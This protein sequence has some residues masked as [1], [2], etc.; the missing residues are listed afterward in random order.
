MY[1]QIARKIS[2]YE[3]HFAD[4]KYSKI[5]EKASKAALA[6]NWKEAEK[7]IQTLPT[8][9]DLLEKLIGK[10]ESKSVYKTLRK[11]KESSEPAKWL[12]LKGLSSLMTHAVIEVEQ[13][14]KEYQLV[15]PLIYEQISQILFNN[16]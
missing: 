13:G 12:R 1:I 15:L 7:I 6:N 14:N 4:T 5:V 11:I 16:L 10:L 8:A 3:I 9:E 2:L